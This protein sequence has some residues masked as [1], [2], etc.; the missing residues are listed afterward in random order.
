MIT[1]KQFLAEDIFVKDGELMAAVNDSTARKASD[2]SHIST[3]RRPLGK[4]ASTTRD[5]PVY[6]AFSY[7]SSHLTTDMLRSIKGHGPFKFPDSRRDKFIADTVEHMTAEFKRMKIK[8][9]VVVTPDSSSKLVQQFAVALAAQLGVETTNIGAFK[10]V[11]AIDLPDNKMEALA[12]IKRKFIDYDYMRLKF[13]GDFEKGEDD[14]AKA[15][16]QNIKHN[17]GHFVAKEMFKQYAK[18]VQ[19]F[20]MHSL[21]GDEEYN[22]IDKKVMVV[23]DVLSSGTSMSEMFRIAKEDLAAAEVYGAVLFSR[24]QPAKEA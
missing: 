18:F 11:H 16:Y 1:F 22:M 5:T 13:H 19:G 2:D 9:D 23:D 3:N 8:P 4:M 14:V 20:M 15:I 24:T 7:H 21:A 12:Y 6:Y 17:N 10:K